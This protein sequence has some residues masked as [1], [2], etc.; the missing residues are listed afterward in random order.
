MLLLVICIGMLAEAV[1]GG[2]MYWGQQN[3][4]LGIKD[5]KMLKNVTGFWV[6][7]NPRRYGC[8]AKALPLDH[9]VHLDKGGGRGGLVR[10]IF[11][12]ERFTGNGSELASKHIKK[13]TSGLSC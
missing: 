5:Q 11:L 2:K 1:R 10:P 4:I 12:L 9:Q 7:L 8:R 13:K 3:Q 6:G